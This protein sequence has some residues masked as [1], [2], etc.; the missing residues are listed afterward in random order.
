MRYYPL[1][2]DIKNRDCLVVGGGAVGTRKVE[3]LLDCGARV[4]VVS[5]ATTL[6]L[7]A[8]AEK[9]AVTLAKRSYRTDDLDGKFLV[10]GATDDEALNRQISED[11]VRRNLLC[12]IADQPSLCNFILPAIVDRG[13]LVIA[14]STSGKSPAFAKRIRRALEKEF[15]PE[16]GPFLAL[17]GKIRDV[18]LAEAHEPEAHRHLFEELIDAGLLDLLRRKR[19]DDVRNLLKRQLGESFDAD[20]VLST[21][22]PTAIQE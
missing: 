3:T 20:G 6:Q 5:I 19:I 1:F 22:L 14:V 10:V 9:K 4:T 11:A 7:D 12:N 2:L 18:L 16:Y 21:V 17:M 13:D 8:L 15:G